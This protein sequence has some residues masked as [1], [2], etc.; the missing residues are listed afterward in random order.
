[1][2]QI[3]DD[4]VD[5]LARH[6]RGQV[7]AGRDRGHAQLV[8]SEVVGDELAHLRVVVEREDVRLRRLHGGYP[9]PRRFQQSGHCQRQA[10]L[11][12]ARP[13]RRS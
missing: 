1:M 7:L 3:E 4:Q 10:H 9:S 13:F 6:H 8:L 11:S 12:T 2:P 5:R